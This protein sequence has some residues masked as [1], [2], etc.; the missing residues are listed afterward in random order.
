M[1]QNPIKNYYA[2]E[3]EANRLESEI[4]KLEGLRTKEII[5]RY[6]DRNNLEILDAGGGAGYYSF[7]LHEKG[8]RVKLVD[9]SPE[10]IELVKK[11]ATESGIE[12]NGCETGDATSL[13]FPDQQ[14]DI[15][16]LLGPLYHLTDRKDRLLALSEAKRV[17]KPG[18]LLLTAVISRYASLFDGFRRDLVFDD[19]FFRIMEADLETGLHVNNTGN[20][21]YFTTAYFHTPKEIVEEINEGGF[22]FEKLIA[23]ESFGWI[24]SNFQEKIKD[25]HYR[26]KLLGTIRKVESNENLMPMSPH[27][28]A[29]ARNEQHR[30]A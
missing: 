11:R 14:F 9:L 2:H 16:L 20:L 21:E 28:M 22:H 1:D 12:L 17:L 6:L 27:I 4:F 29:V 13:R 15:V 25:A 23:V 30:S 26:E 18:G 24:I 10:N 8:H 3:I 19:Q 5:E 7:W